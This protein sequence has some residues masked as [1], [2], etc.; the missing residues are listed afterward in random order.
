MVIPVKMV[1]QVSQENTSTTRRNIPAASNALKDHKVL[2]DLPARLVNQDPMDHPEN[3]LPQ[4]IQDR[5]D[6]LARQETQDL[7]ALRAIQAPLGS[8]VSRVL[9]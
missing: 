3:R 1:V 5:L 7:W 4:P 6:L 2:R 8:L 9:S